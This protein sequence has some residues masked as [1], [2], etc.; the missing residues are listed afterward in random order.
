M[1]APH[2]LARLHAALASCASSGG[3]LQSCVWVPD[4]KA[5]REGHL[6]GDSL[7]AHVASWTTSWLTVRCA[8]SVQLQHG[9][10]VAW[11][12]APRCPNRKHWQVG[13]GPQRCVHESGAV[14][15]AAAGK[16][17]ALG[18]RAHHMEPCSGRVARCCNPHFRMHTATAAADR[19][20]PGRAAARRRTCVC[21]T[22]AT[23]R[24]RRRSSRAA[25]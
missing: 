20:T 9:A 10:R 6:W 4:S 13:E 17:Q 18:P 19:S 8:W 24:A 22:A 23:A 1:L 25:W 14:G 5:F 7:P 16:Y 2:K 21:W 12:N 15:E 11:R 3:T